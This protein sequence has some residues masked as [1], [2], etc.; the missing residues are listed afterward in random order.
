MWQA[1][2]LKI[3]LVKVVLR[4]VNCA[5]S[6]V[7]L[8]LIASTFAIF[9]ATRHL[10]E[11]NGLTPWATS[12]P[13]WPQ[14]TVLCIACISLAMS[15]SIMYFYWKGG[16][17]RA[18]KAAFYA[19]IFA[20]GGFIF[21]IAMWGVSIGIMQGSRATQASQDLWGWSCKDNN[22]RRK[23]FQDTVNYKLVCRQ[24]VRNFPS[25]LFLQASADSVQD[26][27]V[28]CA[29]IEI[30]VE[31][32]SIAVYVFAFYR[33]HTKH[34]LRKSMNVRDEARSSLWLAKLKEQQATEADHE[35]SVNTA[36]N[37]INSNSSDV[38]VA[39]E[40]ARAVPILQPPP[41]GHHANT[42]VQ[43]R[44]QSKDDVAA[45]PPAMFRRDSLVPAT[46]RSVSFQPTPPRLSEQ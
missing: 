19:T 37:Q 30:V 42:S 10:P 4:G 34:Q 38:Y 21:S 24:N 28:V 36:Y 33:F 45:P 43:D 31:S 18:A 11:R 41:P 44:R 46:P 32:I 5:C 16:H 39:A 15:L 12:T 8:S 7:V 26:W 23:L 27:V 9:N 3:R 25:F 35:T 17:K 13:K 29:I 20:A 22:L 2:K 14:I 1:V 40:E 6:L